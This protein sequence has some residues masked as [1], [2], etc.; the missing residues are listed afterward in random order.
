MNQYSITIEDSFFI[1]RHVDI[2]SNNAMEAHKKALL[3][4]LND[5][6]EIKTIKLHTGEVVYGPA[7]FAL[8]S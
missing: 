8:A 1:T 7:G 4:E 3:T 6:E 2:T 5:D